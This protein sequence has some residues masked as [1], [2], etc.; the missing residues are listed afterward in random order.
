MP[1][2]KDEETTI[3]IY[4]GPRDDLRERFD[5]QLDEGNA[6]YSRSGAVKDAMELYLVIDEVLDDFDFDFPNERSKRHFVR[7]AIVDQ[8][9]REEQF[10]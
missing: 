3:G 8:A 6:S 1:N 7:Q 9:R 10:G 2:R 5:E 4:F